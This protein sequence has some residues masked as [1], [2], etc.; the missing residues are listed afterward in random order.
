VK[1]QLRLREAHGEFTPE[2]LALRDADVVG[3]YQR[4]PVQ[5]AG[6]HDVAVDTGQAADPGHQQLVRDP[7]TGTAEPQ[8]V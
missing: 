6:V 1:P 3:R 5:I 2:D 7:A 4:G 8:D